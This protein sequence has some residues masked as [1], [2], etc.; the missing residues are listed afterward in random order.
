MWGCRFAVDHSPRSV[1][2]FLYL[3]ALASLYTIDVHMLPECLLLLLLL[4][5]I[6]CEIANVQNQ[7]FA[8][9]CSR[10]CANRIAHVCWILCVCTL[11][12]NE[13]IIYH[14]N[15]Q[16]TNIDRN[17]AYDC[18]ATRKELVCVQLTQ[19]RFSVQASVWRV[20]YICIETK[21]NSYYTY[22]VKG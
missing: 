18:D 3:P 6:E 20:L 19:R 7:E 15:H 22:R 9:R 5:G 2:A 17:S 11:L 16:A 14:W 4:G 12:P 1:C 13:K 21:H 8:K 10:I